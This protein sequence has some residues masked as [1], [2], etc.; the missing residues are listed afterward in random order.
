MSKKYKYVVVSGCSFSVGGELNL[1]NHG[2]TYGDLVRSKFTMK[3][4]TGKKILSQKRIILFRWRYN[5]FSG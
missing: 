1:V 2:E 5:N 3:Y 4:K